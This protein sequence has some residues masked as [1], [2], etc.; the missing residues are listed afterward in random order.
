M[1]CYEISNGKNFKI[2]ALKGNLFEFYALRQFPPWK[3]FL[4]LQNYFPY[5]QVLYT[6]KVCIRQGWYTIID[7]S[8]WVWLSSARFCLSLIKYFFQEQVRAQE[9]SIRKHHWRGLR[10]WKAYGILDINKKYKINKKLPP[11][12]NLRTNVRAC[13]SVSALCALRSLARLNILSHWSHLRL[14]V[15][16]VSLQGLEAEI[17]ARI[18]IIILTAISASRPC[19][20]TFHIPN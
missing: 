14:I 12:I 18:P 11:C 13:S 20:E 1:N 10:S 7:G 15:W 4:F 5:C 19:R 17:A 9:C 2:H 8:F 16:N 6:F 3:A